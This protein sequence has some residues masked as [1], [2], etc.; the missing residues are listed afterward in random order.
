L[1]NQESV[2]GMLVGNQKYACTFMKSGVWWIAV[3]S[4]MLVKV[5]N[6]SEGI[7]EEV[8]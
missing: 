8:E 1:P 4:K 3:N 2:E 7:A 6:E 5:F